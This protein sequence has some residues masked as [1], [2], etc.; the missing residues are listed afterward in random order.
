MILHRDKS[1]RNTLPLQKLES[2]QETS[3]IIHI[4]FLCKSTQVY[5]LDYNHNFRIISKSMNDTNNSKKTGIKP[6]LKNAFIATIPVLAGYVFLGIA[7]GL[8]MNAHGF[9][10]LWVLCMSLFI[11]AGSMQFVAVDLISGVPASLITV[12]FT[13]IMVNARH[14]FYG[15]SMLDRY[16]NAGA[17]KPYLIFALTDETYSLVC[18]GYKGDAEHEHDYYFFVSLFNQCWWV[19]G[20]LIGSLLGELLPF[21]IVGID[22]ALTALF[23]TVF[24]DQWF[25]VE[26]TKDGIN[27]RFAAVVGVLSSVICLFIFGAENFL[28]PT[29]ILILAV[30]SAAKFARRKAVAI[31]AKSGASAGE[32]TARKTEGSSG[33]AGNAREASDD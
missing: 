22:F 16:K 19:T 29:M 21:T 30:L 28:I 5:L 18:N 12:A 26:T 3:P 27:S 13:T 24:C 25:H 14:I 33:N 15:I 1:W 17:K 7:F 6:T 8:L 20:S 11:F 9:G 4:V 23:V 31:A 32:P 10:V 2:W